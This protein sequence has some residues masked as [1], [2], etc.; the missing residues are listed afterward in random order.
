MKNMFEQRLEA[1]VGQPC[2][3]LVAGPGN[4]SMVTLH[5]G[6]RIQR[7]YPLPHRDKPITDVIHYKG[8]YC[9]FVQGCAWR[10]E[11]KS[12]ILCSWSE[13]E[14]YIET[15]FQELEGLLITCVQVFGCAKD[16]SIHFDD[17]FCL[18]LFCDRTAPDDS[19]N[20]SVRFPEG[21]YIVRPQSIVDFEGSTLSTTTGGT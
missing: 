1:L 13:A 19:N 10:L 8:E 20:Y 16:L 2:W 15:A 11:R 7:L 12:A 4:G 3:A 18:H 21:S 17:R 9:V 6:K 5:I 14:E